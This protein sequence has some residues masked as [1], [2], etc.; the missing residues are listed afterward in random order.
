MRR[1]ASEARVSCSGVASCQGMPE[2]TEDT[3]DTED[4]YVELRMYDLRAT[5]CA[6]DLVFPSLNLERGGREDARA[7]SC[8][9]CPRI[10]QYR[11]TPSLFR[12]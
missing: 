3:E 9:V 12:R 4:A 5:F 11:V 6:R 1:R 7:V 10:T 8:T 2:D